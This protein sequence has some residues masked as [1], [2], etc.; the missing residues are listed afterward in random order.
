MK[1][2]SATIALFLMTSGVFAQKEGWTSLFDG[3]TLNGWKELAGTAQYSV[4]NGAI[5]GAGVAGSGNSFLVTEKEFGDFVLEL[6]VKI[7]DTSSNSGVQLRSH[8]DPAGHEGK[9]LVYGCQYEIDP[10]SRRWTGGI[11][12]EGRRGW[13]YP[14][15]LNP[16]AQSAFHLKEFNKVRIECIGN[17]TRTWINNVPAAY[18]VDMTDYN[19]FI[20]LQV[21]AVSNPAFA[22]QRVYFRNIRIKSI[23]TFSTDFPKGIYVMGTVPNFLTDYETKS[24]WKLL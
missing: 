23:S 7:D 12:D 14:L 2:Y 18:L 17:E 24:G 6:D 21:H 4:E 15:S 10:S 20:A 13:L 3:K 16:K 9:G 19:G 11:Y 1:K 8:Y 5:V 22:G